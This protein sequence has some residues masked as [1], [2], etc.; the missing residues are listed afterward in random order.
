MAHPDGAVVVE[1][2]VTVQAHGA[3]RVSVGGDDLQ[4]QATAVDK[5]RLEVDGLLTANGK[6]Y[7]MVRYR[8][9]P[10]SLHHG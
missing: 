4:R 3:A 5:L 7:V 1:K 6:P 10:F 8:D 9:G 2:S